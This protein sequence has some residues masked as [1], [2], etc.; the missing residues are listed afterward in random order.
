VRLKELLWVLE[1]CSVW[2]GDD[3]DYVQEMSEGEGDAETGSESCQDSDIDGSEFPW[4][5]GGVEDLL[6]TFLSFCCGMWVG[7][8]ENAE[9]AIR[10]LDVFCRRVYYSRCVPLLPWVSFD[11]VSHVCCGYRVCCSV[12]AC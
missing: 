2:S 11:V 8:H 12:G 7:I 9:G 1:M 5:R 10:M 4:C 6:I 3:V